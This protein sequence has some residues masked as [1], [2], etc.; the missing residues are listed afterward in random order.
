MSHAPQ[1]KAALRKAR[2]RARLR[3]GGAVLQVP[4]ADLNGLLLAA[5]DKDIIYVTEA[6]S[7]KPEFQV[8]L[9]LA[10]ALAVKTVVRVK[11]EDCR[12]VRIPNTLELGEIE[13]SEPMVP[14]VR[15]RPERFQIVSPPA[16]FVFDSAGV[17]APLK[18][19][20]HSYAA[21][22]G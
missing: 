21:V 2:Y 20:D 4:V 9:Y 1:S 3:A 16:A 15:A 18:R 8:A 5:Q 22:G 13:V 7:L 19:T 11:P 12:I 14:E 17:L 6:D 10:I